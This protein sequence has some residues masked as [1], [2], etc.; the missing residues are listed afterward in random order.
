[1]SCSHGHTVM[2]L[3]TFPELET[4]CVT[5]FDFVSVSIYVLNERDLT[6]PDFS[7]N[8]LLDQTTGKQVKGGVRTLKH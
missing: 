7:S 5:L 8:S 4:A 6:G 3:T 1:M 2:H